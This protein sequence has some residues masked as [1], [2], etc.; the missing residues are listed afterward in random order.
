MTK[1]PKDRSNMI[2]L[3]PTREE[4]GGDGR[5]GD[6]KMKS[7][8]KKKCAKCK[9]TKDIFNFAYGSAADKHKF[10]Q[11]RLRHSYCKE[12]ERKLAKEKR[13]NDKTI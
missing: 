8:D 2:R 1:L 7:R 3:R 6:L 4:I 5:D 10:V 12:C 9:K 11:Y 13:Q